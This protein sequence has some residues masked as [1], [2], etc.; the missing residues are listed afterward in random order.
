MEM[1]GLMLR[2]HH[3]GRCVSGYDGDASY[4]MGSSHW[5]Q[6]PCCV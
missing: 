2:S 6:M 3:L 1:G 4:S 5:I